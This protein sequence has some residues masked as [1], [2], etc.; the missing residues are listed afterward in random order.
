MRAQT[1]RC[2]KLFQ[3]AAVALALAS[4]PAFG[5]DPAATQVVNLDNIVVTA[6]GYEQQL[7]DAPAS[8]TV[9]TAEDLEGKYYRDVTDALQDIPGVSIEGGAGGKLESTSI[10]IRGLGEAYTLFLVN[11][12]P[13][14]ASTEAYYNGYGS[15]TQVSWMPPLA[16]IERIEVIRGP[17]SSLYGSSALAGVINVITKE[18]NDEWNG[19][20]SYDTVL[21]EN[22]DAGTS[23]QA[24]FYASGPLIKDRLGLTLYGA[25]YERDEDNIEGGYTDNQRLDGTAKLNLVVNDSNSVE[26]EAGR[27]EHENERTSKS[28]SPGEMNNTRTHYGFTHTL[29]WAD[30]FETRT[31][32]ID[33]KVEIENGSVAS[34]YTST[35]ANTKTVMPLQHQT[36]TLGGEYKWETT[37]HDASRFY[38]RT[39]SLELERWQRALFIED[40]FYVTDNLSI[41]GGLRYDEN[42]HYGE[43]LIPRVY[44]VY[45]FSDEWVLKGGVSG[46]YKAPTLKQADS[47]IVENAARSRAF[48]MGNPDLKPE[49]SI[50]YEAGLMWDAMNG[51]NSG[52]TVYYTEFEDQ[53]GKRVICDTRDGSDPVCE[54][55]GVTRQYINQYV[56]HDS[57]ELRG[58]EMFFNIPLGPVELKTNYTFSDS[59]VTE[60]KDDPQSVG[61]PFNNL[62]KHM[63]N[64]GVDWEASQALGLWAKARYKSKTVDDDNSVP[65]YTLVD[66]GGLYHLSES[67][68]VYAG[69]YNVFDKEVTDEDYGKTLD[70][71]RLNLGVAFNF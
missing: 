42:E 34:E 58:V 20:I 59:E 26:L 15:A 65:A 11:G 57:A 28:G 63:V 25:K 48:D 52:L 39:D 46:G 21:Q 51:I 45:R 17:M 31:F 64:V 35:L 23:H 55:N 62:P 60:S 71:R 40:E 66:M 33:E 27:G 41:T 36:L 9:I 14:G 13:L 67:F 19:R 50:N 1:N 24:N 69:L 70:G 68:D 8:I 29:G 18:V 12:K 22:D 5:A 47:N 53:I 7:I 61:Q 30:N 49:S 10:N 54:V 32:V 44:G 3:P 56:N 6:A 4:V 16:S 38:G 43:E 2:H 37:G